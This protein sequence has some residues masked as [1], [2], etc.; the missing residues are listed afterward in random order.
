MFEE[1]DIPLSTLVPSRAHPAYLRTG[2][3]DLPTRAAKRGMA[4]LYTAWTHVET[5]LASVSDKSKALPFLSTENTKAVAKAEAKVKHLRDLEK[6]H[7]E[8]IR[9]TIGKL[10]NTY[11]S[12]IRATL[13]GKNLSTLVKEASK[14]P[15]VAR[16]LYGVPPILLG[17]DPDE[18]A[19][20][21]DEIERTHAPEDY[22]T[23]ASARTAAEVLD[24]AATEFHQKN[25][26][27]LSAFERSDD[28]ILAKAA[29]KKTEEAA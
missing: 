13:K 11:A 12:E 28:V 3:D 10:P 21:N 24:T 29:A 5:T 1:D 9:N 14:D 17:I 22:A 2:R 20:L 7:S 19:T 26:K 23:R 15:A 27:R 8:A 25:M 16:A 18:V 4:E 6:T